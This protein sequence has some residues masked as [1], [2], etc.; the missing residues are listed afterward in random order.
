MGWYPNLDAGSS[1]EAFQCELALSVNVPDCNMAPCDFACD[2]DYLTG[3]GGDGNSGT[4]ADCGVIEDACQGHI[5]WAMSTG[6]NTNPEWYGGLTPD[7]PIDAFQCQLA[8]DPNVPD[9][10]AP[11]CDVDCSS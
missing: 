3:A 6:I 5:D 2:G 4:D 9:C 10:V 8:V 7:S 11:P 1:F